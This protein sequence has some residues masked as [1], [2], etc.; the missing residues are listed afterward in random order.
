MSWS[1]TR[2]TDIVKASGVNGVTRKALFDQLN[3]NFHKFNASG[4]LGTVDVSG[5]TPTPCY[6]LT[7][8]QNGKFVRVTPTKK[9]TFNCDA[10]NLKTTKLDLLTG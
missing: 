8:V 9:G 3:N 5:H 10:R 2:R 6:V 1:V 7:Q 4:M